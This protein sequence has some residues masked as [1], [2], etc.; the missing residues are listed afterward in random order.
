[1]SDLIQVIHPAPVLAQTRRGNRARWRL[2]RTSTPVEL[3]RI[4]ESEVEPIGLDR[5]ESTDQAPC[6]M[7]RIEGRCFVEVDGR[8]EGARGK[9]AFETLQD[10]L[11]GPGGGYRNLRLAS[12]LLTATPAVAMPLGVDGDYARVSG[13]FS[14]FRGHP[15]DPA[16]GERLAED[17]T[18]SA[19]TALRAFLGRNV[20]VAGDRAFVDAGGPLVA[21]VTGDVPFVVRYAPRGPA[22]ASLVRLSPGDIPAYSEALGLATRAEASW[23]RMPAG[24]LPGDGLVGDLAFANAAPGVML[25][26]ASAHLR[27]ALRVPG[28]LQEEVREAFEALVRPA[29]LGSVGM[30]GEDD[31]VEVLAGVHRAARMFRDL[32]P[33][34][35]RKDVAEAVASHVNGIR[36]DTWRWALPRAKAHQARHD[37][38][39]A[40]HLPAR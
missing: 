18:E 30:V 27:R 22:G 39:D 10:T 29:V 8:R 6:R 12:L 33:P 3:V 36:R 20:R 24:M 23:N 5:I 25:Q 35:G 34:A 38:E 11:S 28:S 13:E 16:P 19:R 9:D 32:P 15:S 2:Q 21:P 37:A 7:V 26:A 31:L 1:V 14:D 17:L 40:A 4:A